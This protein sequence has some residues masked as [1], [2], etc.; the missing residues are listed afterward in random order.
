MKR[1]LALALCA[2]AILPGTVARGGDFEPSRNVEY[3]VHSSPG[4]A[5][6]VFSRTVADIIRSNGLAKATIVINNQTDGGGAVAQR[7]VSQLTGAVADHTLLG[8]NM[9]DVPAILQNTDMTIDDFRIIAILAQ[10]NKFLYI[11][12]SAPFDSFQGLVDTL[13]RGE[14]VVLGGGKADDNVMFL[15][16]K[17]AIDKND[18]LAYLQNGD[19][20][21]TAVAALGD[22]VAIAIGKPGVCLPYIDSGEFIP[23]VT[24]GKQRMAG[25]FADVPTF[26]ELGYDTIDFIQSRA[27]IASKHMSDEA[28]AYW[29]DVFCQVAESQDFTVKYLEKY[30]S[31]P[32]FIAG[33][34][35]QRYFQQAQRDVLEAGIVVR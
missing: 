25:P 16:L 28:Y 4:S 21:K 24:E 3:V 22:H 27:I 12:R 35:A 2:T 9:G 34:D 11:T 18:N 1:I 10:D 23:I 15:L 13:E 6:D 8:F 19:T 7:R 32:A 29:Q 33:D 17:K 30:Q 31:Q 14:R 20:Q 26:T 5:L